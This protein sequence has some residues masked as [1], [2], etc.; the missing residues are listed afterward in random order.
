ME[1]SDTLK[2]PGE[3]TVLAIFLTDNYYK[4]NRPDTK[5]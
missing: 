3:V 2:I 4:Q 5:P 1:M